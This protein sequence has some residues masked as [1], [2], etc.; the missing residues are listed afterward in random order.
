MKAFHCPKCGVE[1]SETDPVCPECNEILVS[2]AARAEIDREC[3]FGCI[4]CGFLTALGI[5][6]CAMAWWEST[7]AIPGFTLIILAALPFLGNMHIRHHLHRG[8]K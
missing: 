7:L 6:L 3:T 1:M 4:E 2:D 8:A 5:A